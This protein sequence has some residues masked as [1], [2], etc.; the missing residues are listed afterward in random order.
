MVT[1]RRLNKQKYLKQQNKKLKREIS[2]LNNN[3]FKTYLNGLTLD[4][5]A[6]YSL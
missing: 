6:R 4:K 3:S 2:K 1:L 5:D